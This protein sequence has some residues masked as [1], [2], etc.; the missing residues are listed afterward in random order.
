[1][2]RILTLAHLFF[3]PLRQPLIPLH[4]HG[5]CGG[6]IMDC[7]PRAGLPWGRCGVGPMSGDFPSA[8]RRAPLASLDFMWTYGPIHQLQRARHP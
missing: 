5:L 3:F 1:M 6:P 8:A 4:P 7:T 2:G